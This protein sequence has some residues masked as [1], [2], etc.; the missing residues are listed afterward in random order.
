MDKFLFED[1]I[2]GVVPNKAKYMNISIV[3]QGHDIYAYEKGMTWGYRY[4][5]TMMN[6]SN[7]N[8][9]V[10][11]ASDGSAGLWDYFTYKSSNDGGKTWGHDKIV[12][13]PTPDTMDYPSVCDPSCIY[14]NGYYYLGYTSTV[15]SGGVGN[16]VFVGRSTNP[17]G[18]FEKW[19]GD[20]WGGD[21]APIIYYTD[22]MD[23][24]GA[25]EPS[26][27]EVDG[28]LYIYYTWEV[29]GHQYTYVA[30][31]DATNPNW[32]KTIKYQGVAMER[33]TSPRIDS[34]DIKY[35]EDY[36]KFLA[37]TAHDRMNENSGILFWESNDGISFY[38]ISLLKTNIICHA[39]NPGMMGRPNGHINLKDK[40]Y[41]AYAYGGTSNAWGRWS[42]RMHEFKI[43]LSDSVVNSDANN[44]NCKTDVKYL[45]NKGRWNLGIT[46]KNFQHYEKRLS[47][48]SFDI[49]LF[50]FDTNYQEELI[51][52]GSKVDFC[53]YDESIIGFD[54]LRCNPKNYGDTYVAAIYDGVRHVFKV[55]IL[56]DT[57]LIDLPKPE[58]I[59]FSSAFVYPCT[60]PIVVN[61][62][63]SIEIDYENKRD[64]LQI[65]SFAKFNDRNWMELF[66]KQG[67]NARFWTQTHYQ[68][69]ISYEVS[70]ANVLSV[71]DRGVA[72]VLGK[73]K[74]IV[75]VACGKFSYD[76][77]IIVK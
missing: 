61:N 42:T 67:L 44:D 25:G 31:A 70:D 49:E 39:H 20:G 16:N 22:D 3:D 65:R 46:T 9:D 17:D 26:F 8:M 56:Q 30:T 48:G 63:G 57:A 43:E 52:D 72:D 21:P 64:K 41:F 6:Y 35:V 11:F 7:G 68:F 74:C 4:G 14:F 1:T 51:V 69:D 59:S 53:E 50:W 13:Q 38:T 19:N 12:M 54:G 18:P 60:G 28:K 62:N 10:W 29:P 34:P 2:Q 40:L 36:G 47:E 32:P 66:N 77:T 23:S 75:T 76:L 55:S 37:V 27:V 71:N 45:E 5:P 24:F 15:F 58:I 73:G 33:S